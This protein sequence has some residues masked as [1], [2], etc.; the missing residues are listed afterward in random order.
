MRLLMAILLVIAASA[1][2]ATPVVCVPGTEIVSGTFTDGTVLTS[3]LACT[4]YNVTFE[5][6]S[7]A[8]TGGFNVSG[9][10]AL[11][12]GPATG[13]TSISGTLEF[14]FAELDSEGEFVTEAEQGAGF[15]LSYDMIFSP[16]PFPGEQLTLQTGSLTGVTEYICAESGNPCTVPLYSQNGAG[17]PTTA[18]LPS[19]PE[20]SVTLDVTYGDSLYQ[21]VLTPEPASFVLAGCGVLGIGLA[22]LVRKRAR[23]TR[24][25]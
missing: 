1:A 25:F 4:E 12:I 18:V 9:T 2:L 15:L 6:F 23:S 14:D 17:Y 11:L 16:A 22:G 3:S 8:V 7:L 13:S 19:A 10:S 5:N 21:T 24:R 20:D